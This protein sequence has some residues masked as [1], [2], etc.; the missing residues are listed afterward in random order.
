MSSNE[1][2]SKASEKNDLMTVFEK[3]IAESANASLSDIYDRK[4]QLVQGKPNFYTLFA[5][6][7]AIRNEAHVE[8]VKK[9]Y[10]KVIKS[11]YE[12]AKKNASGQSD[13]IQTIVDKL[14]KDSLTKDEE[15]ALLAVLQSQAEGSYLQQNLMVANERL[16]ELIELL[17]KRLTIPEDDLKT[18]V[19]LFQQYLENSSH[20]SHVSVEMEMDMDSKESSLNDILE[21]ALQVQKPSERSKALS[22]IVNALAKNHSEEK[23]FDLI[24]SLKISEK[25]KPLNNVL[26]IILRQGKAT[27]SRFDVGWYKEACDEALS[28]ADVREKNRLLQRIAIA[29]ARFGE[30]NTAYATAGKITDAETKAYAYSGIIQALLNEGMRDAALQIFPAITNSGAREDAISCI[31]LDYSQKNSYEETIDF[32]ES[33]QTPNEKMHAARVLASVASSHNDKSHTE[34]LKKRY[35]LR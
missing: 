20:P 18:F 14:L 5:K 6:Q 17:T 1:S 33:L 32:I 8:E 24:K 29:V 3:R 25:V 30:V 34:E 10:P 15:I 22:S 4:I 26:D 31:V 27:E 28:L 19:W 35:A 2:S 23:A 21:S 9:R 11:L 16:P 13:F 7:L 12:M